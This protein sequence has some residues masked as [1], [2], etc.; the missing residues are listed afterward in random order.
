V[1][2]LAGSV[3]T[4]SKGRPHLVAPDSTTNEFMWCRHESAIKPRFFLE[5]FLIFG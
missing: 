3:A 5:A 2:T 1:P 4:A